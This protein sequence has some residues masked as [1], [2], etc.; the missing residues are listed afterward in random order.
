MVSTAVTLSAHDLDVRVLLTDGSGLTSRQVATQLSLAGHDVEVLSPDR[1]ALTRFTRRVHRVHPVP[2]YGTDP[3]VW[4]DAAL[5]VYREGRFD[6]LYPT[7]EQVAVLAVSAERL[8]GE[9]VATAVPTFDSLVKVQDKLAAYGTLAELG[10]PQPESFICD[11]ASLARWQHLPVFVKAPIGTATAGVRYVTTPAELKSL[12][13]M[14]GADG[15]FADDGVLIQSPVAGQ[16]V[17]AQALFCH[18]RLVASHANLRVKEGVSGG[19]SHKQSI[20]LPLVRQHLETLGE[21]LGWHGALSLDAILADDGPAYIDVN[22]RLVEPGNAWRAG[23]DLVGPMLD[24]ST[25]VVPKD[26]PPGTT[27]MSTHQLLMAVLGAAQHEHARRAVL[28]ELVDALV[29][30]GEYHKSTEELTPLK[31]D[32]LAAVPL[33]VAASATLARPATWG[34][35][36]SSAV[37][38]YALT[39]SGWRKILAYHGLQAG[40]QNNNPE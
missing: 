38:N 12:A 34:W 3:F 13:A 17:M 23:V 1:L 25:G 6:V 15:L 40:T 11:P 5:T 31:H 27:G 32:L 22:P 26:Q 10:L 29:H 9:R 33:L 2:P 24:L 37:T 30:R 8:E 36:S 21:Y 19:A 14:W 7:Q 28:A 39:A 18:G 16:L 4:L 35:F 20:N